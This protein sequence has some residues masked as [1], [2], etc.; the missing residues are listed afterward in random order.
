MGQP[1]GGSV[2]N[3]AECSIH[4]QQLGGHGRVK[5]SESRAWWYVRLRKRIKPGPSESVKEDSGASAGADHRGSVAYGDAASEIDRRRWCRMAVAEERSKM[6]I[7]RFQRLIDGG[8]EEAA[9][10]SRRGWSRV[11]ADIARAFAP[12][13]TASPVARSIE[14]CHRGATIPSR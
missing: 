14:R 12:S 3:A 11:N 1:K 13:R 9:A 10:S 4:V 8:D 7:G 2:L 6:R 5:I